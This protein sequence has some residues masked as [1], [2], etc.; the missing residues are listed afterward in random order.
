M[1]GS[2]FR[3]KKSALLA[4]MLFPGSALFKSW[5]RIPLPGSY[6]SD[7]VRSFS[8][9]CSPMFFVSVSHFFPV[10]APWRVEI[11]LCFP[12]VGEFLFVFGWEVFTRQLTCYSIF[13]KK[14][15]V[16]AGFS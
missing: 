16:F 8:Y 14:S 6:T 13:S 12:G 15:I 2:V 7:I 1:L 9:S 3:K 4:R 5:H 11:L 10:N